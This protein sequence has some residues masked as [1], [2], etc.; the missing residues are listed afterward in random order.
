MR[1][2]TETNVVKATNEEKTPGILRELQEELGLTLPNDAFKLLFIFLQQRSLLDENEAFFTIADSAIRLL[3]ELTKLV[4]GWN[5]IQYKV[6]FPCRNHL[7]P[8][9]TRQ[10]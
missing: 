3:P 2:H 7:V 8:V 6:A 4:P 1:A 9:S 10:T 5:G